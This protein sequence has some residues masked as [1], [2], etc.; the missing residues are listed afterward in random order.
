MTPA[1]RL[2]IMV[3]MDR[4]RLS[5]AVAAAVRQTPTSIRALARRAGLSHVALLQ[6][7]DG[8]LP[9]SRRIGEAVARALEEQAQEATA[10]AGEIREALEQ[11][12]E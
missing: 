1:P 12:P 7:R 9:A 4:E 8:D 2:T 5:Q 3:I 6:V 11:D 10:L